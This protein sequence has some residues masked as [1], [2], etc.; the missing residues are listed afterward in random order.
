VL[1]GVP[2]IDD[3]DAETDDAAPIAAKFCAKLCGTRM[4]K[5]AA[6]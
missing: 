4:I 6:V 2:R 5:E 3:P 1:Q